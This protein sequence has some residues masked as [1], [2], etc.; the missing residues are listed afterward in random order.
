MLQYGDKV[1]FS[2]TTWVDPKSI[3][4]HESA[5]A[6]YVDSWKRNLESR[7]QVDT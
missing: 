1:R 5:V 3:Y 4:K 2:D 6:D 7:E